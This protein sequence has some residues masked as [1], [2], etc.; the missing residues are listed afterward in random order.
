MAYSSN[1]PVQIALTVKYDN[2]LQITGTTAGTA[3]V[4]GPGF[5]SGGT[6]TTITSP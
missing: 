3:G 6:T 2:A 4:G 5:G 1:D